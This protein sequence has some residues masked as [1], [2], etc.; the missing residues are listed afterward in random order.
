MSENG[1]AQEIAELPTIK[2]SWDEQAQTVHLAFKPAEFRNWDM[3]LAALEMARLKA[4]D[5]RE[6]ARMQAMQQQA[7][8]AQRDQQIRRQLKLP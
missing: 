4:Q 3:I 6:L 7:M 8:D 1:H 5:M 2:L